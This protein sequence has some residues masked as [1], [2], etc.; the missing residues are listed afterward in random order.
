[1]D[2]DK[3]QQSQ[4]D[5]L[6]HLAKIY[7]QLSEELN[8]VF[9]RHGLAEMF[10]FEIRLNPVQ[11]LMRQQP[12]TEGNFQVIPPPALRICLLSQAGPICIP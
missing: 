12:E 10:E 8:E 5:K 11:R 6:Q 9:K 3:T 2:S 1:M 4:D 7:P